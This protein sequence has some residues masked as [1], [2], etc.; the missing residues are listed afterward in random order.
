V[1]TQRAPDWWESAR[2]QAVCVA[3]AG[4]A[5][6]ALSRLTHQRV[7]HTV[8]QPITKMKEPLNRRFGFW[9]GSKSKFVFMGGS[10]SF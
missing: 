3:Q 2:F 9:F 4:S 7:T 5:K 6:A 10:V 8:G 1:L